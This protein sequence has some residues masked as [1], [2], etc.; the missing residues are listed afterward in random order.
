MFLLI[1][2]RATSPPTFPALTIFPGGVAHY[3]FLDS[4][5][6]QGF[7]KMPILCAENPGVDRDDVHA[8]VIRLAL[9]FFCATLR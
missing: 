5:T 9:E 4:C 7:A 3:D 6:K 8:K 1:P 2:A